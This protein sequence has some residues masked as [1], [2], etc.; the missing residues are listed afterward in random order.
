MDGH[1]PAGLI[2]AL[3]QQRT[4]AFSCADE[5]C[6]YEIGRSLYQARRVE[7]AL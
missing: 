1:D 7:T 6:V 3:R 5:Q 2:E 4:P